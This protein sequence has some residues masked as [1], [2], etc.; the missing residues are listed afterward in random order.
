MKKGVGAIGSQRNA[1][2]K[3]MSPEKARGGGLNEIKP[4]IQVRKV[5][6]NN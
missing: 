3:S 4:K 6:S 2:T 5:G 1:T